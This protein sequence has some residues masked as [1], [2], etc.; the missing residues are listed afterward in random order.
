MTDSAVNSLFKPGKPGYVK[1]I[2]E[3]LHG[4]KAIVCGY[5]TKKT[6]MNTLA[7]IGL[8]PSEHK[9]MFIAKVHIP[10]DSTVV[11][12]GYDSDSQVR[13]DTLHVDEIENPDN[14]YIDRCTSWFTPSF[15]YKEKTTYTEPK[16][17][18]NVKNLVSNGL[19]MFSGKNSKKEAMDWYKYINATRSS[20][21]EA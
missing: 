12:P 16:L 1:T 5:S 7:K 4:H 17:D 10:A 6:F 8:Y 13:A 3:P 18:T 21:D 2:T 14:V 19:H 9:K 11:K 20:E 15:K